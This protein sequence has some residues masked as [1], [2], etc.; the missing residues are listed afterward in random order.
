M[1]SMSLKNI[2][3]YFFPLSFIIT[4]S[5]GLII[6]LSLSSCT[7]LES[8]K[9]KVIPSI[10]NYDNISTKK[11]FINDNSRLIM[12]YMGD[13]YDNQKPEFFSN[14]SIICYNTLIS[15]KHSLSQPLYTC[16]NTVLPYDEQGNPVF[17]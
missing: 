12:W 9:T 6:P 7:N 8:I 4:S 15:S 3:K 16:D 5:I 14:L 2:S 11:F 10:K 13:G 1:L 17:I